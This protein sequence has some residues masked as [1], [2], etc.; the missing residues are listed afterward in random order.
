M[1]PKMLLFDEPT[2]SLDP[3]SVAQFCKLLTLLKKN[4]VSIALSTHDMRL[5]K[6]MM[7]RLYL[8]EKGRIIEFF[9]SKKKNIV[10]SKLIYNYLI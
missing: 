7:D 10:N 3:Q 6:K 4:G 9:D 1:N 8:L 2:S 5:A